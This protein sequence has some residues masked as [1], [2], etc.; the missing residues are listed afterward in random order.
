[1]EKGKTDEHENK[2]F[3]RAFLTC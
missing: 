2:V 1:M 3:F